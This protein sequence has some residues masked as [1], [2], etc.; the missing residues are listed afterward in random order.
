MSNIDRK[1]VFKELR[2][3]LKRDKSICLF[4]GG[5]TFI[6]GDNNDCISSLAWSL[7]LLRKESPDFYKKVMKEMEEVDKYKKEKNL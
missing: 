1:R 5:L 7:S 3:I 6:Q 2:F 4:S